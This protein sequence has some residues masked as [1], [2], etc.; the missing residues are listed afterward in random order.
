MDDGAMNE[1]TF[2]NLLDFAQK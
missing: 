2:L 1:S